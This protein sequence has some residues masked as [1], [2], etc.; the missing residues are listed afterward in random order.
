MAVAG[1]VPE[2]IPRL[3]AENAEL[4]ERLRSAERYTAQTL[5]RATRLTQVISVLAE[6]A[7]FDTVVER[8]SVEVAELFSADI[9]LL[10]LGD[11]ESLSVAA[12]WGVRPADV[13]STVPWWRASS[14]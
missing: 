11:D 8:A 1:H 2:A 10:L 3:E 13:P 4:R 9:A 14:A 5:A 6:D 7:D 12:S